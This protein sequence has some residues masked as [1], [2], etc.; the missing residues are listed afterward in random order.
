MH[1][2]VGPHVTFAKHKA[3]R[4]PS[5]QATYGFKT[6]SGSNSVSL[7]DSK[8]VSNSQTLVMANPGSESTPEP[9]LLPVAMA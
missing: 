1:A 2:P 9:G 3:K 6:M 4:V 5:T 7:R 8:T